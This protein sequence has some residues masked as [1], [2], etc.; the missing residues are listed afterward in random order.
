[1]S[2]ITNPARNKRSIEAL[3]EIV[4]ARVANPDSKRGSVNNPEENFAVHLVSPA[5]LK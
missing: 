4:L 5:V 3:K 1:N 2:I